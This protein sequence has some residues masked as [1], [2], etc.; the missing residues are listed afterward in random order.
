MKPFL[1]HLLVVVGLTLICFTTLLFFPELL[2]A[3]GKK[4]WDAALWVGGCFS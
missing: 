4:F 1:S 2:D 3:F